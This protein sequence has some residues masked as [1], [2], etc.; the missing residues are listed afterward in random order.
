MAFG[1]NF[2]FKYYRPG[3]YKNSA[4]FQMQ[5]D[6]KHNYSWNNIYHMAARNDL[7]GLKDTHLIF[8]HMRL[9]V[10]R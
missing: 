6:K 9:D 5:T 1:K 2:F 3:V 4:I 8:L 10:K 7:F